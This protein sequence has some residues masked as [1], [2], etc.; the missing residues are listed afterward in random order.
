[1]NE[2]YDFRLPAS[3]AIVSLSVDDSQV[4]EGFL[5]QEK[6]QNIR[7]FLEEK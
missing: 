3:N 1:M 6:T 4:E 5:S 2:F 7:L